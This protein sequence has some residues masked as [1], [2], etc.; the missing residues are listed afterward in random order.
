MGYAVGKG[1]ALASKKDH[2]SCTHRLVL[3]PNTPPAFPQACSIHHQRPNTIRTQRY[4]G[5]D[6]T[7]G[8]ANPGPRGVKP[9]LLLL[10]LLTESL[11]IITT[12][13]PGTH[14][15]T[16]PA[17]HPTS[18][19]TPT[20][21]DEYHTTNIKQAASKR[22]TTR[23]YPVSNPRLAGAPSRQRP[24]VVHRWQDAVAVGLR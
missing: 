5:R 17:L 9:P 8:A 2:S 3:P 13:T 18:T 20:P 6:A 14:R 22:K 11:P 4:A 10:L 12:I 24:D 21:F 7:A 15:C 16:S 19:S 23:T 1:A